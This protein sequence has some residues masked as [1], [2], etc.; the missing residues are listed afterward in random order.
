MSCIEPHRIHLACLPTP[1]H[2]LT[3]LSRHLGGPSIYIKRDDQTGLAFGG[4][5]ARKLEFLISEAEAGGADTVI[6]GGAPQSNHC[7]QT[8]AAAAL[9]G[10][11][12]IVVLGGDRPHD[13]T[14]NYFLDS[15]LGAEIIWSATGRKG[16]SLEDIRHMCAENGRAAYVI[17]YGGS[18]ATGACGYVFAMK[19]L[20]DQLRKQQLYFNYIVFASSSGGTQAGMMVGARLFGIDS[21]IMGIDV[22]KRPQDDIPYTQRLAELANET[23]QKLDVDYS[24]DSKDFVVRSEYAGEGYAILG[25][26]E[27]EA[28]HLLARSEGILLDPVYTSKAM[29]GLIELIETHMIGKKDRI[30]FWHTGGAPALF[31][32]TRE[33]F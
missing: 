27:K 14:G 8:A 5:K 11:H 18:N 1:I 16:E 12:C 6:T 9:H 31:A 25:Q 13:H 20:R 28:I 21:C 15:L 26:R 29:G 30:L 19:E 24:F 2:H 4:N 3:R 17:P 7:R 23:T 33:L 32:Y 10:M 22:D